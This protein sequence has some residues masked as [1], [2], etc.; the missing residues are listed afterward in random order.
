MSSQGAFNGMYAGDSR[1]PGPFKHTKPL[2][3]AQREGYHALS[4]L[5]PA[6]TDNDSGSDSDS[7]T[8]PPSHTTSRPSGY[9]PGRV[10]TP[11]PN[12]SEGRGYLHCSCPS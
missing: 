2:L 11:R 3:F 5:S 4:N 6:G 8:P 9:R 12:P 1:A 10:V 7:D